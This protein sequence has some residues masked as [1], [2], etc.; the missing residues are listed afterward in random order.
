MT[1]F[2]TLART[3]SPQQPDR[4][5]QDEA[6]RWADDLYSAVDVWPPEISEEDAHT[7]TAAGAT[8]VMLA[9]GGPSVW[10]TFIMD[11]FGPPSTVDFAVVEYSYGESAYAVINGSHAQRLHDVLTGLDGTEDDE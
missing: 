7:V 8:Q 11:Q 2:N 6:D 10:I 4:T 3:Q 5:L 9:N 1:A